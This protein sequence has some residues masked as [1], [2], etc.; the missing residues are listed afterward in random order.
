MGLDR[1]WFKSYDTNERHAKMKKTKQKNRKN[2]EKHYTDLF[3]T[4]SH[5]NKM[6]IFV[7]CVITFEPINI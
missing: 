7:F 2:H 3:F 5:K 6:E 1:N 4:K